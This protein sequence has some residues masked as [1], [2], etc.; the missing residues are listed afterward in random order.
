MTKAEERLAVAVIVG[1]TREGRVGG[2]VAEWFLERATQRDDLALDVV[3]LVD[4]TDLPVRYPSAP[5]DA[6]RRF[7]RHVDR[8]DGFVVVTPEYN[9]SFPAVLKQAIDFAYDEWHG[10]P[11][12]FVSYGYDS[13][14]LYAVEQLRCVFTELH[15][16]SLRDGVGLNLVEELPRGP[17]NRPSRA[18]ATMLDQLVWWGHALRTARA[19]HPYPS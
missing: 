13:L 19:A 16:M 8:A 10:K 5:T 6:M 11:V 15:A 12:G 7:A 4:Y 1:S 9:R 18:V 14:G 17:E 2:S 3:D